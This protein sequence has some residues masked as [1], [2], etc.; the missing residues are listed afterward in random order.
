MELNQLE[1]FIAVLEEGG[2][3]RA[4][5]RLGITQPALSYQIK[6]LEEELG[7]QVF[8]RGPGGISPTEAGRVLLDHAHQVIATVREAHQAVRE[9]SDG[10][11]GE[12]R[13]GTMKCAGT[14]FLPQ[15]LWDI[16]AK[17]PSVRPEIVYRTA[18]ELLDSLLSKHLDVVV[19]A[20][21]PP[22]D[23]LDYQMLF[24][25]AISIVSPP[26]HPF[27]SRKRLDLVDL[28]DVSFVTLSPQTTTGGL[29]R[30]FLVE[31]GV[32]PTA[33]VTTDNVETV[34]RMVEAGMGVAFLPDMVTSSEVAERRLGRSVVVPP[35]VMEVSIVTW[36]DSRRSR[37]VDAFIEELRRMGRQWRAASAAEPA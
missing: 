32:N 24:R 36:R 27:Y 12:I 37:A 34:K 31:L 1:C 6:R 7:V 15:V 13:I 3:K 5:S 28:K 35:L 30:D 9:L 4:S 33:A 11:T 10:V 17:H 20:D 18:D 16:R 23:R 21:P 2:F 19:V 22:D 8:H 29:I 26:G 14:Y 25:E